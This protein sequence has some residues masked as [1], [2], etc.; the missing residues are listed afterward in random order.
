MYVNPDVALLVT[1][2]ICMAYAFVGIGFGIM[3]SKTNWIIIAF[4]FAM[5]WAG[6]Y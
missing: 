1:M 5:V 6:A 3:P 4:M 2:F